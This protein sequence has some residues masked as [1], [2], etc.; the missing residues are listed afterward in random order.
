MERE[1][2]VGQEGAGERAH[3]GTRADAGDRAYAGD[4]IDAGAA[5]PGPRVVSAADW[6]SRVQH[7]APRTGL[8]SLP[9]AQA[10]EHVLAEEV[11]SPYPL[12]RWA[13]SAMDGY[14]LRAADAADA[15][16][17]TPVALR[18]S[19]EVVAG[20]S[21]DPAIPRGSAV[22]IMTG[23]AVPS[24]ADTVIPV[25]QTLGDR[26][27]HPWAESIVRVL[28]APVRGANIR[29][30]GE[31]TPAS[32][33]LAAAGGRLTAA[34]CAALAA[35]GIERVQVRALPRVAVMVT[36]SELR[37]PG[38]SLTRGS[39]PESNS[40]LLAG[41]LR[42]AG[43]E[44]VA[45]LHSQDDADGVR[46]ALTD[47]SDSCDVIITTGGIGPGTRDVMRIV[48]E[49][50]PGV[51]G[52]RV[53][54]RPGQMQQAGVLAA[55]SFIFALPGNPVSAAVGFE[56]F[57]RPML[58]AMQGDA[59]TQRIRVHAVAADGWRGAPGRL[60]V[61]P[62]RVDETERGLVCAPAVN[63]RSVS[64]S[65]GGHGS[66]DGYALIEERRGD[67]AAGETVPVILVDR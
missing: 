55:G 27:G 8:L 35:A 38:S 15:R 46:A 1:G 56:L 52:V 39:I 29:P 9:V 62:V 11:R 28:R 50:E 7:L 60:Q 32:G 30:P 13:N 34:R 44:P 4:R 21:E 2:A 49:H 45:V 18:V 64:H 40:L 37:A 61:L 22:R 24:A 36:G 67:V 58:L 57:V 26:E 65:V 48:L 12:P 42:E 6:L 19:G 16:P 53:A 66:A 20:S 10:H 33:L 17:D 41:M 43:I 25:E 54:V 14:A 5:A 3:A 31:D 59:R 63:P 23:A 47:L 51:V